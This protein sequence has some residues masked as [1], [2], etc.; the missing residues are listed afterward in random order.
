MDTGVV[1]LGPFLLVLFIGLEVGLVW[2]ALQ[3]QRSEVAISGRK[4]A[5]GEYIPSF[6]TIQNNGMP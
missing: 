3:H 4:K 5:E 2:G 6:S 1:C